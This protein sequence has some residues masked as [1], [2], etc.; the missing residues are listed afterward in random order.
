[1]D[2]VDRVDSLQTISSPHRGVSEPHFHSEDSTGTPRA[3]DLIHGDA[4]VDVTEAVVRMGGIAHL[5]TATA[6]FCAACRHGSLAD[7]TRRE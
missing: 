4:E 3:A 7:Q 2:K 1:M 5:T 6:V